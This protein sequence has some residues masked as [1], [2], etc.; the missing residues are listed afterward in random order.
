MK[1]SWKIGKLAG[2]DVRVHITLFLLLGW[3]GVSHW[4]RSNSASG[5]LNGVA[6]ILALFA[7]VVLHE[8]GH[9]LAAR[10]FGIRTR[11][12]TLLPIGGVARLERMPDRPVQELVVAVAGPAVNVAIGAALALWLAVTGEL[13][14]LRQLDFIA[15]PFLQRLLIANVWLALFNM[16]PAFPM[17]GGRVLRA[18]LAS[19]VE[20]LR[21]TRVAAGVGQ[22][23]ALGFGFLG[24]F[25]NP[26]LL[27]IAL[28]VWL[29]ASQEL[30]ATEMKAA[31]SGTPVG[32]V[33]ATNFAHLTSDE[34]IENA[35]GLILEGWPPAFP[36]INH[37]RLV[38][39]L[40]RADLLA[41]L[42]ERG[43]QCPVASVMR[44]DF[45]TT[46]PAATVES[47]FQRLYESAVDAMPVIH[48]GRVI[49]LLTTH[50]LNEYFA[51]QNAINRKRHDGVTLAA[52]ATGG[53][54]CLKTRPAGV[55]NKMFVPATANRTRRDAP[56]ID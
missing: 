21:A 38:G 13:Q 6:F 27:I 1:W 40:T 36:I 37:G 35:F 25:G 51:I 10:R 54:H 34:P 4:T 30:G 47:A 41:A 11:D 45:L 56:A 8:L 42:M 2:I 7:C 29:G 33:M 22:A 16:L 44:S 23:L 55:E 5:A 39:V 14:H 46:V 50:G 19:R 24:I 32:A 52:S 9:A 31:M 26:M 28:F 53:W 3:A 43:P 17:D 18:L 20:R 49:G 48:Q 12:I 15:G